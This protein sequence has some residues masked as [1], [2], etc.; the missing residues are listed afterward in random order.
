MPDKRTTVY[1]N[2]YLKTDQNGNTTVE[3]YSN[4]TE[5]ADYDITIEGF[6]PEG[7]VYRYQQQ[8]CN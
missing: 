8:L 7:T 6:I 4:D 2:P 5:Q 3:F 1:W